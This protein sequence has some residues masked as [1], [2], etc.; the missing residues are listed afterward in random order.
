MSKTLNFFAADSDLSFVLR[1]LE[2]KSDVKYVQAGL[3]RTSGCDEFASAI[4]I[5]NL[6][7]ASGPDQNQSPRY[8]IVSAKAEVHVEPIDQ[9]RGGVLYAIDQ[10]G[11]PASLAFHGGG[12]FDE[13]CVI[14][15]QIGTC[16]EDPFSLE[17]M[18]N[19]APIVR[20]N[21]SRI[22]SYY[23]GEKAKILMDRGFRLTA[24]ARMPEEYDLSV[25]SG[26]LI[27]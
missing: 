6:G 9:R 8:L 19:I 27:D 13:T 26:G 1:E 21:F 18:R 3:F 5:P 24:D 25:S 23:V 15:G 12:V 4:E 17:L 20:T 14:A 10:R 22:K 16:N 7:V 11:N 2:A